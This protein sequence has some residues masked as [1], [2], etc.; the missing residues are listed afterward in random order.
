MELF[1]SEWNLSSIVTIL[2][3]ITLFIKK[4]ACVQRVYEW[5]AIA[6]QFQIN[7][8]KCIAMPASFPK[9]DFINTVNWG[10]VL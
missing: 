4:S 8:L 9:Y 6:D 5:F 10:N 2:K 7:G 1:I 3:R